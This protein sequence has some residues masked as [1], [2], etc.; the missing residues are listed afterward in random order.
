[1]LTQVGGVGLDKGEVARPP[2]SPARILPASAEG[3]GPCQVLASETL[4]FEANLDSLRN[5][6]VE[7]FCLLSNAIGNAGVGFRGIDEIEPK[8]VFLTAGPDMEA[9]AVVRLIG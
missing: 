9:I 3:E 1:L 2:A 7:V 8:D 6:Q 5:G 4:G